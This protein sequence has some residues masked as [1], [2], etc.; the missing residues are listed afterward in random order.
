M[1]K[2]IFLLCLFFSIV[3][4]PQYQFPSCH[5]EWNTS[6][7]FYKQGDKISHNG[8]NYSAKWKT[9]SEPGD[10]SWKNEGACG[11]R[12]IG[13]D[14]S[15]SHRVI[16]YLP[17]WISDFD[18]KNDFNYEVLTNINVSFLMFK[19]NNN[20]Y[21]S[22]NF[23][24]V[25]FD[26]FHLRKVDSVLM[27]CRVLKNAKSNDIK[28]SVALGGA[29]DYAFLWLMTKYYNND[30]KLEEI[31]NLVVN[32]V[33]TR[34]LDGIDLD[35]ECWWINPSIQG[36]S[37]QGGRIRGSKWGHQDQGPHPAAIGM[38]KLSRKLRQKMPNKLITTAVFGTS[39]Y[40]N[41]YDADIEEYVDWIGLMTYD[42][43]GSWDKSPIGP[44]SSLHKLPLNT[45][46]YQNPDN[47][48]YSTQDAF[49]YWLGIAP[50]TWNHTGGFG[51]KKDKLVIGIPLYGYDFSEK[52]SDQGKGVKYTPYKD[53]IDEFPDAATSYDKNDPQKLN[54]HIAQNGKNIYFD[55]PRQASEKTRYVKNYGHQGLIIWELTQDVDYDSSSSILKAINEAIEN[56]IPANQKPIVTWLDLTD[57]IIIEE[58]FLGA[59]PLKVMVEDDDGSISSFTFREGANAITSI[60]KGNE[61]IGS[62]MPPDFGEYIL[63]AEA[64]DNNNA[65]SI[66]EIK[67]ILKKRKVTNTCPLIT[68]IHPQSISSHEQENLSAITLQATITDD[69]SVSSVA[70]FINDSFVGNPNSV[71]VDIFS[72][73]WTPENFGN[74]D[75]KILATDNQGETSSSS[76]SFTIKEKIVRHNYDC[77]QI[78]A[79]KSK[80][81]PKVG[82][83]V[84]YKGNIYK[85][86]SY[87]S[88]SEVP[89]MSKIWEHIVSCRNIITP[90]CSLRERGKESI[91]DEDDKGYYKE[92]IYIANNVSY[93]IEPSTSSDLTFYPDCFQQ[94][95]GSLK[96]ERYRAV[97]KDLSNIEIYTNKEVIGKIELY[98]LS[99]NLVKT[100]M[101]SKSLIGKEK[102]RQD[103]SDLKKGIYI[104]KI[105]LNDEIIIRKIDVSI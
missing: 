95:K 64:T 40:G 31:A 81:Y 26:D 104:Y 4:Y 99:G 97:I 24:S 8:I 11:D 76:T 89:S 18:I 49:E 61:Y 82:T 100:I 6:K 25:A 71:G 34:K 5:P 15:G 68:N 50:S 45:Y 16:G 23:A 58:E 63:Y 14:Y 94:I 80:V 32:Y 98:N 79:W 103:L 90:Q 73:S 91:S 102:I 47:P 54:G 12:D 21:G 20:D 48:I 38:T 59:I 33:N 53:I 42:F 29:T 77:S 78:S 55:T 7:V 44:H 83:V 22:S 46:K 28:V 105:F 66:E 75:F 37:E 88:R 10:H 17:T 60:K 52:K 3:I 39:W 86:K 30:Q 36:T 74:F 101:P 27:D 1:K 65:T 57:N 56:D 85:N 43:T 67:I 96:K 93:D 51:V 35:L 70:F 72:L 9:N 92:K 62:F 41:N 13:S 2:I 19:K 69:K 84:E 87:A